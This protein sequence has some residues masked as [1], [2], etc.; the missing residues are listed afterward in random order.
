MEPVEK[1]GARESGPHTS[2]T[3]RYLD[4]STGRS[5]LYKM[6]I[7]TGQPV[8]SLVTT[9]ILYVVSLYVRIILSLNFMIL[10]KFSVD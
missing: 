8:P 5:D 6:M 4:W 9:Y 7:S 10:M 1:W 3:R 2:E